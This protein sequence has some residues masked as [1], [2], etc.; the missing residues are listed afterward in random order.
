MNILLKCITMTLVGWP[1]S[2]LTLASPSWVFP[3]PLAR[4]SLTLVFQGSVLFGGFRAV[5]WQQTRLRLGHG[6]GGQPGATVSPSPL[7]SPT[8]THLCII[9]ATVHL[10]K[11][12]T[13]PLYP[14]EF[15]PVRPSSPL[16]LPLLGFI[17]IFSI[18]ISL[19]LLSLP[20]SLSNWSLLG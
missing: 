12:P 19:P 1:T 17:S 9:Q 6:W 3:P 8:D 15:Q 2:T 20:L 18:A 10:P 14:P 16:P 13:L 4:V 5:K 11:L 7:T